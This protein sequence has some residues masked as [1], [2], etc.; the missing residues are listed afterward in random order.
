MGYALPS[1]QGIP[2]WEGL[3]S[4]AARVTSNEFI[5]T[6]TLSQN[7]AVPVGQ[8]ATTAIAWRYRG[9]LSVSAIVKATFA[10]VPDAAMSR[11]APQSIFADEVHHGGSPAR[12]VQFT[13]DF[14]P[15][16][17]RVDV[18]FTGHAYAPPAEGTVESMRARLVVGSSARPLL[19]KS[20]LIQKKGGFHK[21]ALK[22]EN[23]FG[24]IGFLENPY[25][26]GADE[27]EDED[28]ARAPSVLDPVDP[29]R[30]AGFA[31]LPQALVTRRRLLGDAP[32]PK[33]GREPTTLSDDLDWEFFQAA[34][35]DQRLEALAGD[36]E[37][38]LEGLVPGAPQMRTRLPGARCLAR[39]HGLSG[40]GIPEGAPLAMRIDT[41][42]LSGDEQRCTLTWRGIFGVPNEQALDAVRIV[43]GVELPDAPLAWPSAEAFAQLSAAAPTV[44]LPATSAPGATNATMML[45]DE[46]IEIISEGATPGAVMAKTMLLPEQRAATS[47][48][49]LQNQTLPIV[50]RA[51][52]TLPFQPAPAGAAPAI[53]EATA[54]PKKFVPQS[55]ATLPLPGSAP[56][57]PTI[58]LPEEP[59]RVI[60]APA[61]VPEAPVPEAPPPG[62]A[63]SPWA[64]PAEVF[65]PAAAKAPAAKQAPR[66]VRPPRKIDIRAKLYGTR[67]KGR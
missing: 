9:Q 54:G 55:G 47:T 20:L 30:V 15:M 7:V 1:Q 67:V 19:D 42:H 59:P 37:I 46:D 10:F 44:I 43:A 31:P 49:M 35:A 38:R 13:S 27:D 66:P 23:A 16:R 22:Y 33:L 51:P 34:P 63:P 56:E 14:V 61:P 36:E 50:T 58:P 17:K 45:S 26:D 12:S 18:L 40:L 6:S 8:V 53:A 60:A 2:F 32:I 48:M 21:I 64:P 11:V 4:R 24:G 52:V 65:T 5:M 62:P 41:L 57:V 3:T 39:I 28:D 25:G 29:R